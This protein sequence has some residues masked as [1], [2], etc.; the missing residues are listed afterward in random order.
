MP[1]RRFLVLSLLLTGML[2]AGCAA[3]QTADNGTAA[4]QARP[5]PLLSPEEYAAML[6]ADDRYVINVHT[7]DEGSIAGTD[8]AIP[9]DE[10]ESRESELPPDRGTGLAIYCMSGNMSESAAETLSEMGYDDIVDLRGG[11][12]AWLSAGRELEP[13][14]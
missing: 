10:L 7:P 12:E 6:E 13:A 14:A 5:T 4:D 2:L 8:L 11:M 3:S 9:F 1:L